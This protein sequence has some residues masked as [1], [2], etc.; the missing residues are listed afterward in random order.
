MIKYFVMRNFRG[1]CSFVEILKGCM[2]KEKLETPDP[3][4]KKIPAHLLYPKKF[5]A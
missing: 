2:I 1:T 3:N 5:L 4:N